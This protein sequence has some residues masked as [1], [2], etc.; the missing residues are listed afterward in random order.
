MPST[1]TKGASTGVCHAVLFG[2]W[3]E[4]LVGEWGALEI[5][6][7]PY[8]LKKQGMIEITGI[9]MADVQVKHA[10]SFAAIVDAL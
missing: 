8:R 2:V 10:A 9:Y 3:P 5:L 7:D 6:V 1:L 4:L